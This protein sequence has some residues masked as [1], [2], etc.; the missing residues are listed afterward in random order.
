MGACNFYLRHIHNFTYSSAPLTDQ[1]TKATPPR[2]T[3]REEECFQ[4]L[5]KKIA[6]SNCP[7]VPRPKGEIVLIT[8]ASDVGGGWYDLPMA[9]A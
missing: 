5:K 8:D 3:A 4:E 7:G 6:S 2:R 9:G 1:I